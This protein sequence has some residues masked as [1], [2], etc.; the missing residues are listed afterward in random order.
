MPSAA[1]LGAVYLGN[2][3]C[4]FL[5]WAPRAAKVEVHLLAPGD[6]Y[7]PLT[8]GARGY[9]YGRVD[10]VRPGRRYFYRLD[11]ETER[12]DPA[13]RHQPEDVHGP[14]QVADPDFPWEDQGWFGLSLKDFIIYE[15]HVGAF[16][17]AGTF[18]AVIPH[19]DDLKELGLT[20]VEIMPVAQ[21]PG[22][23]NWGYDG[24]YPFAVQQS[25]GGPQGL[26]RLV[27]ACHRRGLA[28]LLDVVYNHL[29]PEG[30][31]LRD[32]GPYFTDRRRTP[33]GEALNFDGP[34]SE[35]VRRF[36]LENALHWVTDFHIDALRL[37]SV[38]RISDQSAQPFL[39][40]LAQTVH[41]RAETL[42]RRIYLMAESDLNDS[43]FIRAPELGGF[44]LDVHWNDDFHHA[45]HHLLTGETT[46]YYQDYGKVGHLAKAF[47]DGFIYTG[48]YS[49][50]RQR[51]RGSA[52]RD[53]SADRFL[54]FAQNHDQVG[55]RLGGERLSS[56]VSFDALKLAA[57]AVLL[58]PFIPLLFMGEEYGDT[59][60]FQYFVSH[61][62]PDLIEAVRHGRKAEFAGFGWTEEP[63]DPQGEETFKRSTL[64]RELCHEGKHRTLYGYYRELLRLRREHP[65]LAHLSK[66]DLE[67]ASF[68]GPKVLM[69]RRW[70]GEDEVCA[71]FHFG[72][73]PVTLELPLPAGFWRKILDSGEERWYG[74]GSTVPLTI[75]SEGEVSL[76]LPP[77]AVI[78]FTTAPPE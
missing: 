56:L 55:N 24:V 13:S 66:D 12:P 60:P 65:A 58:S 17:P 41:D 32:F 22:N 72:Q 50:Y 68:E 49:G 14:S 2:E 78:L 5:V 4:H 63:P 30:N 28:V 77:Q 48:E 59:A 74:A 69:V 8:P 39:A 3:Q 23:R 35:E 67:V 27:N 29:G 46:G 1:P 53:L 6:R 44:G 42:N 9:H 11:G 70:A 16:T 21:F 37:D 57:G 73:S 61:G 36:F 31:Y 10:G 19:L 26:K 7:V 52:C 40:G 38:D 20:A 51:R 45:L 76:P 47:T 43:R 64:N 62:D 15:L 18:D 54:V 25:Y 75:R 33:W 71:I 34:H